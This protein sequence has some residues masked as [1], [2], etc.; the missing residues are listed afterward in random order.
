MQA[1]INPYAGV[2]WQNGMQVCSFSHA[3]AR[4]KNND[5][6]KGTVKQQ[7]LDN[8]VA[9]GATHIA[10]S[11]YY[12]SEP[13]YPLDDWFDEVPSGVLGCPNAEHHSFTDG[14]GSLH[15]NGIGCTAITGQAGGLTPAGANMTASGAIRYILNTLQYQD[16]GGITVNHP[17]WSVMQNENN[18]FPKW[19]RTNSAERVIELL[20]TDDRVIGMEIRNTSSF[21]ALDG[22]EDTEVNTNVNSV[23]LWDEILMTG[24]RCW[25]FCVPDHETEWGT[26]WTGR[27]I[28][29]VDSF[30]E[31]TCL[32][33]Y[34][35]GNFYSKIFDSNLAFSNISFDGTTF[36]V[37][38]PNA[39]KIQI[40]VDGVYTETT[41]STAS[42]VVPSDATYVRAEAW[43]PYAWTYRN[44]TVY[45]VTEKIYS[46][47]VIFK[48]YV[49]A[50]RKSENSASK[51]AR[52]YS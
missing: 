10:F 46:N 43:M 37:S 47:P 7:Y 12:P 26:T 17:G 34:R 21:S 4:V 44:G 8:A 39:E 49:P 45:N 20:N 2:D 23:A 33:A 40:I 25:G 27:N 14:W 48:A 52:F 51:I 18:G 24:K 31:H 6:T 1:V 36:S 9:G 50:K 41:G 28:L 32:K 16:G 11:N 30:D 35:N 38:A 15:M 3:H 13:F 29:L 19:T 22:Y 5:G 42:T